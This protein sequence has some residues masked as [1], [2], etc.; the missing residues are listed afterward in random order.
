[1]PSVKLIISKRTNKLTARSSLLSILISSLVLFSFITVSGQDNSP[2]S[3]YGLGDIVPST[4]I[5]SRGMGSIAA[6][7][8]DILSINFNNP[9]SY[10]YFQ[11]VKEPNAKKILYG[12]AILDVGLNF[13]TRTLREPN[14]VDKFSAGNALFSHVQIGVPL[15]QN[16]GL[17]FGLRPM[18]RINYQ[19]IKSEQLIDPDTGLPIDSS[20]TLNQG[21]GGSYLASFGI[22]H[23]MNLGTNNSLSLGINGGYLFGN[24]EYNTRRSLYNSAV[25]YTSGNIQTKT[26]YGNLF[27]NTGLQYQAKL[28]KGLFLTIGAY[29]NWQQTINATMDNIRG[30]YYF[31]ESSGY[32]TLDSVYAQKNIKGEIIYPSSYT[33]G[34]VLERPLTAKKS[35]W[36]FGIDYMVGNWSD[37]RFYGQ[38]DLNVQDKWE[39]RAGAQLKPAPKGNYFSTVSYRVGTFF[40]PDYIHVNEKLPVYGISFGMGLP[41]FNYNRQSAGQATLVNL[42]MEFIKRGNNN[43]ALKENMFRISAGFAFSDFW[44]R[45]R[46]YD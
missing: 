9:A 44:F 36:L 16:W 13:E 1:M 24:Q 15:S 10:G 35:G 18:T 4:N 43:N 31:D 41:V 39:L 30:T 46:K 28:N 8:N 11:T 7:Y 26:S 34:F 29:G 20:L 40:G 38:P 5:N 12:R 3:R 6:G 37:Y 27:F 2:Y 25:L 19:L 42:A 17:S 45:K 22:G 23:K 14:S 33:G 32:V 21:E